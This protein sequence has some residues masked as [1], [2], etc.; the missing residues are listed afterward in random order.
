MKNEGIY[1]FINTNNE[2]AFV[3]ESTVESNTVEET[4]G[5]LPP[6]HQAYAT[7]D[8]LDAS[9]NYN[10][11]QPWPQDFKIYSSEATQ[12]QEQPTQPVADGQSFVYDTDNATYPMDTLINGDPFVGS[13]TDMLGLDDLNYNFQT[14]S[15]E[16]ENSAEQVSV[17]EQAQNLPLAVTEPQ[18]DEHN[19]DN[20]TDI[21]NHLPNVHPSENIDT[22]PVITNTTIEAGL[23][24][25]WKNNLGAYGEESVAKLPTFTAC[26]APDMSVMYNNYSTY[27]NINLDGQGRVNVTNQRNLNKHSNIPIQG[28]NSPE[29]NQMAAN[30]SDYADRGDQFHA[31]SPWNSSR[32]TFPS[33]MLRTPV[34]E[35]GYNNAQHFDDYSR[36]PGHP[37][38]YMGQKYHV[39]SPRSKDSGYQTTSSSPHP[40][41]R[42]TLATETANSLQTLSSQ[43]GMSNSGKRPRNAPAQARVQGGIQYRPE[44]LRSVG[45]RFEPIPNNQG[46]QN[47]ASNRQEGLSGSWTYDNDRNARNPERRTGNNSMFA[48]VGNSYPQFDS[49]MGMRSQNYM[50][51]PR[52]GPSHM[53]PPPPNNYEGHMNP[54]LYDQQRANNARL[55]DMNQALPRVPGFQLST[56]QDI[57]DNDRAPPPGGYY[58]TNFLNRPGNQPV[59][60]SSLGN[61]RLAPGNTSPSLERAIPGGKI[62]A[63]AN[64]KPS[65]EREML[66]G[67]IPAI[68][69]V[70]KKPANRGSGEEPVKKSK[71]S[72]WDHRFESQFPRVH[73][74][75]EE[76][77]VVEKNYKDNPR[78]TFENMSNT[79]DDMKAIHIDWEQVELLNSIRQN[80][81]K[82][83]KERKR[84][85][86]PEEYIPKRIPA[87]YKPKARL[88]QCYNAWLKAK[89]EHGMV[90]NSWTDRKRRTADKKLYKPREEGQGQ[91]DG[92]LQPMLRTSPEPD[93]RSLLTSDGKTSRLEGHGQGSTIAQPRNPEV[94]KRK[95]AEPEEE[96][97]NSDGEQHGAKKSRGK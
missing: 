26:P 29:L 94:R 50:N 89:Q 45:D 78:K 12:L 66:G 41:E 37:P 36:I 20:S 43:Y 95:R 80:A 74:L 71:R 5:Y 62:P 40:Q 9:L 10:V 55:V 8:P 79:K 85:C 28:N 87:D 51:A 77:E 35:Q 56:L 59:H 47:F 25:D 76:V 6:H 18:S 73:M 69:R 15:G 88:L 7:A 86:K 92:S 58:N 30:Q 61:G 83:E 14:W 75:E 32:P 1:N 3:M 34:Q 42:R 81:R 63:P 17:T 11:E 68:R 46:L 21:R 19:I 23:T 60:N 65:L 64:A 57:T 97:E 49:S 96:L 24:T 52:N 39:S 13:Y 54:R 93:S 38:S 2:L 27:D 53:T 91:E 22:N 67:I 72:P 48:G 16:A 33:P 31:G 70:R 82:E 90:S 44:S 4:Q 84:L